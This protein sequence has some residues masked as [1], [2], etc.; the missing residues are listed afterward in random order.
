MR[1]Q[2]I[3]PLLCA[4][5][6]L[7]VTSGVWAT[8]MMVSRA[9][10][11]PVTPAPVTSTQPQTA[12]AAVA[13]SQQTTGKPASGV[14]VAKAAAAPNCQLGINAKPAA[15][16]LAASQAGLIRTPKTV[17]N[18]TIYG[19]TV[20][21][22]SNQ[23]YNCSPVVIGGSHFAASTDYVMS[24]NFNIRGDGNNTCT[25]TDV[26]VG[27]A[28]SQTYPAWQA[29]GGANATTKASWQ[30]FITN[31]TTHEDG[32]A[33]LDADY[34]QTL[35]NTLKSLPPTSCA[36]ISSVANSKAQSVIAALD[37][38]NEAYDDQTGHGKTQGA[39]LR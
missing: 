30:R 10:Q 12:A 19:D 32:H 28:V 21:Q 15:V 22:I 26:R 5:T 2:R 29:T 31:L 16:S 23:M 7:L 33:Q 1:F 11:T 6:I 27:L 37:H 25:L 34:A 3:L 9:E 17:G 38:A 13:A 14:A 36:T 20:A 8:N 4:V 39:T 24:W 35:L 18:Y